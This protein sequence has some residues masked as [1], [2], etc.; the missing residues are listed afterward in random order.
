MNFVK[1]E[2]VRLNPQLKKVSFNWQTILLGW[3]S[4]NGMS[5]GIGMIHTVPIHLK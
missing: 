2:A 3:I 4:N 1:G 5:K